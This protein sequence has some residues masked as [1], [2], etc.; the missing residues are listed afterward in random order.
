MLS[1]ASL[2]RKWSMRKIWL[3]SNVAC[4]VSFS[5]T[6]LA[7]SVPNGFSMMMRA[8]SASPTSPS[9]CTHLG[10]GRGRD[11]QVVQ[12]GDVAAE[13]VLELADDLGRARRCPPTGRRRRAAREKLVPVVVGHAV[14]RE[15]VERAAGVARGSRRR[16]GRR[17]TCRRSGTRAAG[18]ACARW[19]RPGRSLRRARSPVAPNS[20]ITCGRS[21][22]IRLELM[23]VGSVC[24]SDV[25]TARRP[26]R[27]GYRSSIVR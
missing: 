23:S 13:L 11:A 5:F 25:Q 3:S 7:R 17:A 15:L 26:C 1:A 19:N 20:T 9:C 10:R 21:G 2:P 18:P 12:P 24:M 22:E 27:S 8:R 6:A 16:R 14:V 4:S